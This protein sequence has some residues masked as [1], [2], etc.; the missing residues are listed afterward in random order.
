MTAMIQEVYEALE[1]CYTLAELRK[2]TGQ[3]PELLRDIHRL[4][5]G[6]GATL[7]KVNQGVNASS[8]NTVCCGDCQHFQAELAGEDYP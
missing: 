1:V 6:F 8:V 4:K 2:L 5:R 3:S 7:E